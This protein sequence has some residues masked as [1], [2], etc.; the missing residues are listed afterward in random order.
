LGMQAEL[1]HLKESSLSC[2]L[3]LVLRRRKS[4]PQNAGIVS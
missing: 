1:V 2:P 3:I 4:V